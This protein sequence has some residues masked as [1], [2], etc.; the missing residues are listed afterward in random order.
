MV[1]PPKAALAQTVKKVTT[2]MVSPAKAPAVAK[3]LVLKSKSKVLKKAAPKTLVQLSRGS[4]AKKGLQAKMQSLLTKKTKGAP[5]AAKP[6]ILAQTS[7]ENKAEVENFAKALQ[8]MTSLN[9]I[10][11]LQET[12]AQLKELS[13]QFGFSRTAIKN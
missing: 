13:K 12:Q 8:S 7:S 10:K 1:T 2:K 9:G 11:Q 6:L 3:K 5:K 4:T